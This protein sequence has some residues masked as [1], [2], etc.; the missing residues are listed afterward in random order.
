MIREI[1]PNHLNE[2]LIVNGKDFQSWNSLN[3]SIMGGSSYAI[4]HQVS[5]GLLLE[6]ELIEEGGGFISCRSEQFTVPKNLS[7]HK[8]FL[9]EIE[10]EGRTLKFAVSCQKRQFGLSR[11]FPS[12]IYWVFTFPT[13]VDTITR[14]RIPFADLEPSIRARP[15]KIPLQFDSAQITQFQLLYSK[16]GQPGELTPGFSPGFVKIFLHSISAYS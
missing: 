5:N 1:D 14:I 10:G 15:V 3:D 8:G 4:C 6:G 7:K 16:F 13:E 9:L 11:I 2:C 12:R